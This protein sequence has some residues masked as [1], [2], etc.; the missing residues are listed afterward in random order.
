MIKFCLDQWN[1]NKQKL[2]EVLRN[3]TNLNECNYKDLVELI[4]EHILNDE[5]AEYGES[6]NKEGITEIDDGDYQGTLLYLIP[7]N[8]YQPCESEYLMTFVGYGSCSGCDTLQNIQ[9]YWSEDGKLE[10][11]Q[12]KEFMALC[13]DIITNM[14]KPYNTGWRCNEKFE[15]VVFESEDK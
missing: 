13:K 3:A 8:T 2:E 1:K 5:Y 12:V 10:E 4:T 7:V 6:F 14:I 9:H 15:T 11:H